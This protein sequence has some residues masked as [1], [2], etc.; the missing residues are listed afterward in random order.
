MQIRNIITA[1][2]LA[3]LPLAASAASLIIPAAGTG[4]GANGSQWQSEVTLHTVSAT[5]VQAALIFHDENGA[6]APANIGI[7]ARGTLSIADV[8]KSRFGR[9]VAT[10]AIEVVV[11]DDELA[12]LAVSSRTFNSSSAGEFGQDIPAVK[13]A[14]A[15]IAGDVAVLSAPSS[16]ASNRFNFGLYSVTDAT[17]TWSLLRADG[18]VAATKDAAYTGGRQ[19]QYNNGV[20]SLFGAE[21]KNDDTVHAT[22]TKG[23]A[24]FYGSAVNNATGDPTFV[25]GIRTREEIRINFAG[26]DLD[27]NGTVDVK[28][29]NHDGLLD[30]PIDVFTTSGFPNYF[31]IVA[32]GEHGE[33]ATFAIVDATADANFIDNNGTI[34]WAPQHAVRGEAGSLAVRI[35]A[36]G[37]S[38]VVTIPVN[39]R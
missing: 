39:Y 26:I 35:T 15:A 31:R 1:A 9:D 22:V 13:L 30:S 28:D 6:T 20:A 14:D 32:A 29:A 24:I 5:P 16:A 27:E 19:K 2:S 11:A 33:A 37:S 36:G 18:T 25:P 12:H 21:A 4:P 38:A 3:L 8:V 10:G 23:S 7:P 17:V 34:A